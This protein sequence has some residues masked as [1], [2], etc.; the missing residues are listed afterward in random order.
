[1][2]GRTGPFQWGDIVQITGPKQKM[3]TIVLTEG[4]QF[5]TQRGAKPTDA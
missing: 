4:K 3:Y 5:G 2:M 1:M